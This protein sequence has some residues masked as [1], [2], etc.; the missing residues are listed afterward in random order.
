MGKPIKRDFDNTKTILKF[1]PYQ[2]ASCLVPSDGVVADANGN[3]IVKAGTPWPSNDENCLGYLL[4]DVDV[5]QGAAPGTYVY[6]GVL[7]PDKLTANSITIDD[8]ALAATPRVTIFGTAYV[9]VPSEG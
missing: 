6:E 9:P 7:D 8:A 3:K 2:G 1:F 5:T 4:E